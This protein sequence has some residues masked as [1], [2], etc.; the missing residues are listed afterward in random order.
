MRKD[1][2]R[3]INIFGGASKFQNV[4]FDKAY[5]LSGLYEIG[6]ELIPSALAI[7]EYKTRRTPKTIFILFLAFLFPN[8]IK[9]DSYII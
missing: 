8:D 6:D 7:S 2:K 3:L 1:I 9:L 5:E 4:L